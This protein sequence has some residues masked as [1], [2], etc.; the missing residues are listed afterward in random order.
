MSEKQPSSPEPV[1]EFDQ[2]VD[3]TSTSDLPNVP[4]TSKQIEED[5]QKLVK[6]V[7]QAELTKKMTFPDVPLD[8]RIN[9]VL[10]AK[11]QEYDKYYTEMPNFIRKW[12]TSIIEKTYKQNNNDPKISYAIVRIGDFDIIVDKT[13]QMNG[14]FKWD[15]TTISNEIRNFVRSKVHSGL[16]TTK[17]T[18]SNRESILT[19]IL[20][21][22]I[23]FRIE[24]D[25]MVKWRPRGVNSRIRG[26]IKNKT[27]GTAPTNG[28][29]GQDD[30]V[31]FGIDE[32]LYSCVARTI[33]KA[34]STSPLS[35]I[36]FTNITFKSYPSEIQSVFSNFYTGTSTLDSK[37]SMALPLSPLSEKLFDPDKSIPFLD[38]LIFD[39]IINPILTTY[40]YGTSA[41]DINKKNKSRA[42]TIKA[43]KNL[44]LDSSSMTLSDSGS[45]PKDATVDLQAIFK[46]FYVDVLVEGEI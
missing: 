21:H 29:W 16:L 40:S 34:V 4:K 18:K 37:F 31:F 1:T 14:L 39:G 44:L 32:S 6:E 27:T 42:K 2:D 7:E 19:S 35:S 45:T 26:S 13:S 3:K 22:V 28:I 11:I 46:K 12:K 8:V 20:D 25:Y 36:Q 10:S 41:K 15:S 17:G 24:D 5:F 30:D 23:E 43:T 33:N 9:N 38:F